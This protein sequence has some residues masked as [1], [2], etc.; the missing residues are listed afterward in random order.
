MPTKPGGPSLYLCGASSPSEAQ[1]FGGGRTWPAQE[2]GFSETLPSQLVHLGFLQQIS[3]LKEQSNAEAH[4]FCCAVPE[5]LCGQI[6]AS[7]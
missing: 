6:L 1:T 2:H 5:P 4:I 7:S 3:G